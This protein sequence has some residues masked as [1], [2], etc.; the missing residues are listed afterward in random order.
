MIDHLRLGDVVVTWKLDRL[1]RCLK[2]LIHILERIEET[3]AGLR[4]LTEAIVTTTS[5]GRMMMQMVGA[6]AEFERARER[7]SAELAAARAERGVGGGAGSLLPD[8]GRIFW[9]ILR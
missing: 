5:A 6:F 7:T 8:S 3:G 9:K 1:S 2:D 4:S